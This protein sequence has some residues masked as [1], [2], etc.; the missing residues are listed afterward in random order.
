M[1][2]HKATIHYSKV[3]GNRTAI[4]GANR[5]LSGGSPGSLAGKR[6]SGWQ[7]SFIGISRVLRGLCVLTIAS[8]PHRQFRT[9]SSAESKAQPIWISLPKSMLLLTSLWDLQP[10]APLSIT[11]ETLNSLTFSAR[12]GKLNCTLNLAKASMQHLVLAHLASPDT[13]H[14][15]F[16]I[17][18]PLRSTGAKRSIKQTSWLLTHCWFQQNNTKK[19]LFYFWPLL[20]CLVVLRNFIEKRFRSNDQFVKKIGC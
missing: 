7:R 15:A 12:I 2:N 19:I 17:S 14:H 20:Q 11:E 9:T 4:Q 1:Q 18:H 5:G 8:G 13:G 3:Q 10:S 16:C 6:G